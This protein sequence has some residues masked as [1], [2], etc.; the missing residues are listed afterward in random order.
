M[1][2]LHNKQAIAIIQEAAEKLRTL[3]MTSLV[4]TND[5]GK[6]G[7]SV[8]LHVGETEFAAVAARVA[9]ADG[10]AAPHLADEKD[11]KRFAQAVE[12]GIQLISMSKESI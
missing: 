11:R 1:T 5:L 6:F 7:M 2:I 9:Q 8:S 3:G 4:T 10:S 12:D